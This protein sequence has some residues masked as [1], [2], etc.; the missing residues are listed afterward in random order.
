MFRK[1]VRSLDDGDSGRFS[2]GKMFRL[3]GVRCPESYQFGGSTAKRT[4][5]GMIARDNGLVNAKK[6]GTDAYGR[7]LMMLSNQDGS[8]NR[9]MLAK[10]YKNKG[11]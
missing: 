11:R 8:I 1:K 10:G 7:D 9:R 3:V 5:A 6:V 4:L 2:D